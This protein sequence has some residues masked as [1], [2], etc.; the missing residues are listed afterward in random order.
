MGT[1]RLSQPI[2]T[3]ITITMEKYGNGLQTLPIAP[4]VELPDTEDGEEV[5]D[6]VEVA[7]EDGEVT[8]VTSLDED[9]SDED[10]E[11]GDDDDDEVEGDA[12]EEEGGAEGMEMDGMGFAVDR[13]PTVTV[14]R[15]PV[16]VGELSGSQLDLRREIVKRPSLG[17]GGED[18]RSGRNQL[19][20]G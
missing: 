6:E 11:V 1:G 13:V 3:A 19:Q 15:T 18:R 17:S 12:G 5:V 16:V 8:E 9:E 2:T 20:T 10:D 4:L 7:L 14:E